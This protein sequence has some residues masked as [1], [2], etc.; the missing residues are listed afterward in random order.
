MV[1]DL[2]GVDGIVRAIFFAELRF[3]RFMG[4]G[5]DVWGCRRSGSCLNLK[6]W[7]QEGYSISSSSSI[8][9]H[10]LLGPKRG[11]IIL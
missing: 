6:N 4:L 11:P 2:E 3:F 1:Y 7:N 5:L 9:N 10:F 8:G